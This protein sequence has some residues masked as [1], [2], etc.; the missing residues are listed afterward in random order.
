MRTTLTID[1]SLAARLKERARRQRRP[2]KDVVN[3]AIARGL[4]SETANPEKSRFVVQAK[5]LGFQPGV[6]CEHLN[7]VA[8]ELFVGDALHQS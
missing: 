1:D 8:D 6:D 4:G 2:F 5:H 7:R 3:E